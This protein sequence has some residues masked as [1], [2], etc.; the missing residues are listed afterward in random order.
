MAGRPPPVE[1]RVRYSET[2]QMGTYYNS[3]VLEWFEYGRTE[4]CRALGTPYRDM[5]QRG[6]LLP[7]SEAHVEYLGKARYDDLLRMT[8]RIS[9]AGRARV[10]FDMHI[11]QAES[12]RAVCRGY[13]VHAVTDLTGKPIRPPGWLT[14]IVSQGTT[15]PEE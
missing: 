9:M 5:E 13:T 8:C 4:F 11:D 3:R 15:K 1:F 12:G 6:L 7:V 2:D 14:A 10:R